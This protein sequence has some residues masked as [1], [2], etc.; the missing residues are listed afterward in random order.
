MVAAGLFVRSLANVS[1]VDLGMEIER[2]ATFGI[3]PELNGLRPAE[4]QQLFARLER[5]L[6]TLPGVSGVAAS[7]VP[8]V[9]GSSWGNN[10]SV[11]GFSAPPDADT[12][13]RFNRVG[14]GYFRTLGIPLLAGR[15]LTESDTLGTPLVAL[16]NQ[17]FARKF[18]LGR[19]AVGKRMALGSGGELDIAIVGLVA[20]SGYNEVKGEIPPVFYLPWRQSE[21]LGALNFYVATAGD[22]ERL[23]APLRRVVG[24]AA[25][26]LPL[27]NLATMEERVREN[28]F[29]DR[30]LSMLS[31]G[32]AVLATLLAAIGLYGVLAYAVAQRTHE[33]G[34]RVALGADPPRVRGLVLRQVAVIAGAGAALGLLAGAALGRLAASVLYRLDGDDPITF[35]AALGLL[36]VVALAA[37]MVPAWRA[38]RIDPV[39]ALRGE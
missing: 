12:N 13:S 38:S 31:A 11:E 14:P 5:E 33:I 20:D 7:M 4:S 30:L 8:L 37:G 22:P 21:T 34:V 18:G 25:P 36:G 32:F 1:R 26:G 15:E 29:L 17:A 16:V 10:V 35:A 27:E 39:V 9:A 24:R 3:S 19:D 6:A 2:L 23:I 28:V